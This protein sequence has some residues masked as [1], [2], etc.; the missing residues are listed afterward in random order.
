M[1]ATAFAL[2][3]VMGGCAGVV[4]LPSFMALWL[5]YPSCP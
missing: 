2:L 5:G 1:K 3:A 4:Y